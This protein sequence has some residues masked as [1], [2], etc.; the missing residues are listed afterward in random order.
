MASKKKGKEVAGVDSSL[1]GKR[2]RSDTA[3]T[4]PR[5]K[6]KNPAVLR[7]FE[8]AAL[9]VDD[10]DGDDSG[11]GDDFLDDEFK[12]EDKVKNEPGKAHHLPFF[13]KEENLSEEE[14]Q[15]ILD[16]RYKPGSSFVTYAEDKCKTLNEGNA[17]RPLSSD[18]TIWKVKCMVG[19]E[20]CSV[21]C[22]MQKYVDK[23]SLGT[24]LQ[25]ISAFT[26]E[27]V[28]GFIYIEAERQFDINEACKGI[29]TIYSSRLV[30]VAKNEVSRSFCVRRKYNEVSV[31]TCVR[32]KNGKYKGDLAQ[33][34][35]V[36]D[37][38]KKATVKLVPRIDM[39]A[40]A[41]NLGGGIASKKIA[42]PP[43]RLISS[44]E[45]EEFRPFIQYRRDR[46][47]GQ[48]FEVLNGLMLKDG[49]LYK[50]VSTDSLSFWGVMPSDDELLKFETSKKEES[51]C[52]EWLTQLYGEQKE[53]CI[54]KTDKCGGKVKGS[55]S[56]SMASSFE[57]HDLVFFNPKGFGVIVGT[58][59][60][61]NFKILK[62]GPEGP[63]VVTVELKQLK[64]G[65]FDKK[66]IA[67]DHHMKTISIND[68]VKILEG[69]LQGQQGIV[70]KIY[71]GTMFLY[72]ENKQENSGYMCCKSQICEKII[73]SDDA[74]NGK[75]GKSGPPAIDNFLACPKSPLSPKKPQKMRENNSNFNRE[76]KDGIF[77]IG[78]SLRIRVGPLKG[79]LC[80]VL[81]VRGSDATVKLDSQQKLLTV[82]GVGYGLKW[83]WNLPML[84][85]SGPTFVMTQS[86][87]WLELKV[88]FGYDPKWGVMTES[89]VGYAPQWYLNVCIFPKFVESILPFAWE[90]TKP[91][92]LH[93]KD[94]SG[95]RMAGAGTLVKVKRLVAGGLS[96]ERSSCPAFPSSGVSLLPESSFAN[97]LNSV[98]KGR[99]A[100]KNL[101]SSWSKA[102]AGKNP[103]S[104]RGKGKCGEN[105]LSIWRKAV[106]S[107]DKGTG[108][109]IPE[110]SW[111]K[112]AEKW[113][114][115]EGFSGSKAA[116][117]GSLAEPRNQIVGWG[118]AGGN[119]GD[120]SKKM[121]VQN[122]SWCKPLGGNQ[123]FGG[124]NKS[125]MGKEGGTDQRERWV[126]TETFDRGRGSGGRRGRGGSRGGRDQVGRGRSF[127]R[128]QVGVPEDSRGKA[129][130]K[131]SSKDG[132]SGTKA[133]WN[134]GSKNGS[135]GSF[136]GSSW[137]KQSGGS[138]WTKQTH[139]NTGDEFNER[140]DQ[141]YNW[142]KPFVGDQGFSGWKKNGMG[143][144][145]DTGQQE[146]WDR[147]KTFDGGRG[148]GGRRGRG[149]RQGGRD[150]F[151][152]GRSFDRGGY[153][154]RGG[155]EK[156]GFRG[157]GQSNSGGYGGRGGSDIGGCRDRGRSNRGGY[158]I[159][160]RSDRGGFQGRGRSERGGFGGRGH[161]RK[162]QNDDWGS[163]N[164]FVERWKSNDSGGR[165]N[166]D[167][168]NRGQIWNSGWNPSKGTLG[169]GAANGQAGGRNQGTTDS[170]KRWSTS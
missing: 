87:V 140:T 57:V 124:W 60:D 93:E 143:K 79:Y 39:H 83:R 142:V 75:G 14:L 166:Q 147:T 156:G 125:G 58:E 95:D 127:A 160:G 73:L 100:T 65:S 74:R 72:D 32:V 16:E 105:D 128:G 109:K 116:W 71:R 130:E 101:T 123:G 90:S 159:R 33:V 141:E 55:T 148:L 97:P 43:P 31:G 64:N 136:E 149:G 92:D 1:S 27:H 135:W 121:T 3:K 103:L 48:T 111:G 6:R 131:W 11:F 122:D 158:G 164:D 26:L 152:R 40:M 94:C 84:N 161:G 99:N 5:Q 112:A 35:A 102:T 78:Q 80:H 151:V 17:V 70:K 45:L 114:D 2:K 13:L 163:K 98:D 150:Q 118:N 85:Q 138:S 42:I 44:T 68:T 46:H 162:D 52:E 51:D 117:N 110:G 38:R 155:S 15:K 53:K 23:H 115:I 54:I 146:S 144:I 168:G 165:W 34:I 170:A 21:F 81:A 12:T 108:E 154:G 76:D 36:N 37:A 167:N 24:E 129:A 18:P 120:E 9:E 133:I 10:D 91:F 8:D 88:V 96:T 137:N 119:I 50:K 66:F 134:Q 69:P 107:V 47:T 153:G 77:S 106:D 25:I 22:L 59:N 89:D 82:C 30:P 56:S 4:G 19:R 157:R 113:S 126:R 63:E 28:R 139:V 86:D 7:F 169:S 61:D 49:Y 41:E 20:R 132:A 29:C 62:E 67:L 104:S 145:E